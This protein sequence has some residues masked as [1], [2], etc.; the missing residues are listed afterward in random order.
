M[1][2][3][4]PCQAHTVSQALN[5][6]FLISFNGRSRGVAEFKIFLDRLFIQS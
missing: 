6:N 4:A 1:L 5:C 2:M 3:D